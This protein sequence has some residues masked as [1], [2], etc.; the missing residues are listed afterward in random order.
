MFK[1]E[2]RAKHADLVLAFRSA[3]AQAEEAVGDLFS[4]LRENGAKPD[5]AGA[6]GASQDAPGVRRSL[7]RED[8]NAGPSRRPVDKDEADAM[9]IFVLYFRYLALVDMQLRRLLQFE[10]AVPGGGRFG[11]Q[12]AQVTNPMPAQTAV[13]PP[14]Q[15]A[16]NPQ[17]RSLRIQAW[18]LNCSRS[19]SDI[20]RR[21][22]KEIAMAL[23]VGVRVGCRYGCDPRRG[24]ACAMF[25]GSAWSSCGVRRVPAPG[26]H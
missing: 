26:H 24:L 3:S 17:V 13:N 19:S 12:I 21:V 1:F 2:V 20:R 5:R 23:R 25:T 22:R 10:T 16:V 9:V 15:T 11:L 7:C 14:A 8:A 6:F 18:A 4:I